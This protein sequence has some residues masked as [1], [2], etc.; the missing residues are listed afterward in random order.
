M[1]ND[2]RVGAWWTARL[3]DGSEW[4]DL[5]PELQCQE[6]SPWRSLEALAARRD[7]TVVEAALQWGRWRLAQEAGGGRLVC[8]THLDMEMSLAGPQ[9]TVEYRFVL[10]EGAD[11]WVWTI[12]DGVHWWEVVEPPGLRGH[13]RMP[14]VAGMAP[15]DGGA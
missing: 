10:S 13:E 15:R 8:G 4:C 5:S 6:Q 12:T 11:R 1:L 9:R 14:S 7:A 2:I 3:S